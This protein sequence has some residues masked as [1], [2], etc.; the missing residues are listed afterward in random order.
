MFN[1]QA[2]KLCVLRGGGGGGGWGGGGERCGY[3]MKICICER[4]LAF[5][6]PTGTKIIFFLTYHSPTASQGLLLTYLS[7]TA[8]S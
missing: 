8:Y 6:Q 2:E 7:P 5:S 1:V 4:I 3:D